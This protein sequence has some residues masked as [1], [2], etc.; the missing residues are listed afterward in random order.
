MACRQGE[1]SAAAYRRASDTP[2]LELPLGGRERGEAALAG[3]PVAGRH[4]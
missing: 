1:P 4:V 2:S 3:G